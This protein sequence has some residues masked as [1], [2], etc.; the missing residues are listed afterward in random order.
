MERRSGRMEK[1]KGVR[2]YDDSTGEHL[3]DMA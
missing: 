1:W 3:Y 2:F